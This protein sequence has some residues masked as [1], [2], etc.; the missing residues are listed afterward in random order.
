MPGSHKYQALLPTGLTGFRVD[1]DTD[2]D[3]DSGPFRP[4]V[5]AEHDKFGGIEWFKRALESG[6][7][8]R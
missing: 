5:R 2:Q 7:E 8:A 1:E 4:I 6:A 3:G